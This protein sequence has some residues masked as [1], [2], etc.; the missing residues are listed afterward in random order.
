MSD[1][2]QD[3][4]DEVTVDCM[5]AGDGVSHTSPARLVWDIP[6][7]R[8]DIVSRLDRPSLANLA[9]VSHHSFDEA[10]DVLYADIDWSDLQSCLAVVADA[11]SSPVSDRRQ[12]VSVRVADEQYRHKVYNDAVTSITTTLDPC[13]FEKIGGLLGLIRQHPALNSVTT[14][15]SYRRCPN[16][17]LHFRRRAH[18]TYGV[19]HI[20]FCRYSMLE[21]DEEDVQFAVD[22]VLSDPWV[23]YPSAWKETRGFRFYIS[24]S[25]AGQTWCKSIA[26]DLVD[27]IGAAGGR[28]EVFLRSLRV[29]DS[30]IG[31]DIAHTLALSDDLPLTP[32][33]EYVDLSASTFTPEQVVEVL[34]KFCSHAFQIRL[35]SRHAKETH[36]G[37]DVSAVLDAIVSAGAIQDVRQYDSIELALRLD[38]DRLEGASIAASLTDEDTAT[39]DDSTTYGNLRHLTL[40][41]DDLGSGPSG[42]DRFTSPRGTILIAYNAQALLKLGGPVCTYSIRFTGGLTDGQ[43]RFEQHMSD[44]LTAML[45][46]EIG[47]VICD[48]RGRRPVGWRRLGQA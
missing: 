4:L 17:E 12:S 33:L 11:V 37:P 27:A 16:Y 1:H 28:A 42:S 47:R 23:R 30:A 40:I 38:S 10:A 36:H 43:K 45:R 2:C 39:W 3:M 18:A 9:R 29:D 14:V 13:E 21:I 35:H 31:Y 32:R 25:E 26:T 20:T 5:V 8:R 24:V 15:P 48:V 7:I 44:I 34:Q 41:F 6:V 19:E 22:D 46:Q